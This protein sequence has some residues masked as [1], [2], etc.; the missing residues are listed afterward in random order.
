MQKSLGK[1]S[2]WIIGS[3]LNYTI[4]ISRYDPLPGSSYIKF[5]KELDHPQESLINIRN[6]YDN[7]CFK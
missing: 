4:N 2:G 6:T 5:A 7:K 1:G 3:V